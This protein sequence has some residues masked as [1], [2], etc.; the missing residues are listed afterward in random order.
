MTEVE[1][2]IAPAE[3]IGNVH[4][5]AGFRSLCQ[6]LRT[7]RGGTDTPASVADSGIDEHRDQTNPFDSRTFL[8]YSYVNNAMAA[9][10][11]NDA[12]GVAQHASAAMPMLG[13]H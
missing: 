4:A 3:R 7:L 9:A 2:A 6:L 11:F 8:C 5:V 13:R 12:S 1:A 10:I